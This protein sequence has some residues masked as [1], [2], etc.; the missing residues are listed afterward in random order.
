MG[1]KAAGHPASRFSRLAHDPPAA[2]S[3]ARSGLALLWPGLA[4][5][6]ERRGYQCSLAQRN[7]ATIAQDAAH[8]IHPPLYYWLLAGWV[9]LFGSSE[10]AVRS[11]SALL[12][13][14][15][16]ALTYVLG[17]LLAG[18]WVGSG[19]CIP[20][21]DPS[22]PDLLLPG[23]PNVHAAGCPHCRGGAGRCPLGQAGVPQG[24][25]P[26]RVGFAQGHAARYKGARPAKELLPGESGRVCVGYT[27]GPRPSGSGG[28]LYALFLRVRDLGIEH[29]YVLQVRSKAFVRQM[30]PWLLTQVAV[31]LLYLPWLP[32]AVRQV[33]TWPAPTRRRRLCQLWP[34]PG[35]GWYSAL[36]SRQSKYGALGALSVGGRVWGAGAGSRTRWE[37]RACADGG[38]AVSRHSGWP[39]RWL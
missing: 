29:G 13:V 2:G 32:I 17:R 20:G 19:G 6:V 21:S 34:I 36:P 27:G 11:L 37:S 9:R 4:E 16:V 38:A 31:V 12:G 23:S 35:V 3:P 39:C 26:A 28:A 15:L 18:R 5:L 24:F 33:T 7:L 30:G 22:F 8:D 14:V 10:V 25:S 1:N